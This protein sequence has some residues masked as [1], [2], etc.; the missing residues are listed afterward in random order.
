MYFYEAFILERR[1]YVYCLQVIE[2]SI[3]MQGGSTE[4]WMKEENL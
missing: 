2:M 1:R 3:K 4:K